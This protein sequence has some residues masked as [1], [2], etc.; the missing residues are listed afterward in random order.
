MKGFTPMTAFVRL[1]LSAVLLALGASA[2][3]A[4]PG[5]QPLDLEPQFAPYPP[6]FLEQ[7]AAHRDT[8]MTYEVRP[9][10][11]RQA[12][13]RATKSHTPGDPVTVYDLTRLSGDIRLDPATHRI[14]AVIEMEMIPLKPVNMEYFM[15][16]QMD[17]LT[18]SANGQPV[19]FSELDSYG[20]HFIE[21]H[22]SP[23][24]AIGDVVLL[25]FEYSGE[26]DCSDTG[27]LG[28]PKCIFDEDKSVFVMNAW[29]PQPNTEGNL[30]L[31]TSDIRI[32]YPSDQQIGFT[33]LPDQQ[34]LDNGD[35]TSTWRFRMDS[36]YSGGAFVAANYT[37]FSKGATIPDP[38]AGAGMRV[39]D[40]Y[41]RMVNNLS[42]GEDW[43]D[44]YGD[45]LRKYSRD[46]LPY[47]TPYF[48]VSEIPDSIGAGLGFYAG[49]LIPRSSF[50]ADPY[51]SNYGGLSIHAH[52][53]AHNWFPGLVLANESLA[54]WLSEGFAEYSTIQFAG[55]LETGYLGG[56]MRYY[57][58]VLA[59][60]IPA[61]YTAALTGDQTIFDDDT[62]YFY[63]TYYKGAL[64]LIQLQRLYGEK[65]WFAAMHAYTADNLYKPVTTRTLRRSLE[66]SLGVDL[67][68]YFDE[69]ITG[70]GYPTYTVGLRKQQ[71]EDGWQASVRVSQDEDAVYTL[72]L[73]AWLVSENPR[74]RVKQQ[75][76]PDAA[77]FTW[78]A[79]S[80]SEPYRVMIDPE[81][82]AHRVVRSEQPGDVDLSGEV[83]GIDLLYYGRH[84]GSSFWRSYDY[85]L[86]MDF[87]LDGQIDDA[88]FEAIDL[89][90]GSGLEVAQ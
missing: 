89:N 28:I 27:F 76:T 11:L 5:S 84:G 18:I 61:D 83:D 45:I 36:P 12:L 30:Q 80:A 82:K 77:D 8:L 34:P 68:D 53:A 70:K 6:D 69:W 41:V 44:W 24:L 75:I 59:T 71:T 74:D 55:G 7:Q 9:T 46:Y 58:T 85:I 86:D 21:A 90:F 2:W 31:Y 87:N 39:V 35:G 52:E 73:D 1:I 47:P 65:D 15:L 50:D 19:S 54:P 62:R 10:L 88:D 14:E 29:V 4:A 13:K 38:E 40:V 26:I 32:T 37:T 17:N 63:T 64:V 67:S 60:S 20:Y 81:W 16:D 78:S 79:Q 33:G 72:P 49:I 57:T 25:R 3:A 22:F 56:Y 23:A 48:V 43:A 51:T 42:R 66:D